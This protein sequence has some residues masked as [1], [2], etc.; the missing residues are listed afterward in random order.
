MAANNLPIYSKQ[1]VWGWGTLLTANTAKDGTGTVTT[2][3]TADATEGGRL[4]E[5]ITRA[6]GTNVATV[7]RFFVNNGGTNATATNNALIYEMTIAAT[8][9]SEV[10]AQVHNVYNFAKALPPG[11]KINC[12]IG[13]AVA[14]GLSTVGAGGKY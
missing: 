6:L 12:A 2:V 1:A 4:E 13:T 5:I 10:A 11:Y 7:L 14:A 3:W 9:L 8:T